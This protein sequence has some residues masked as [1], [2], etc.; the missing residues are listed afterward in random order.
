MRMRTAVYRLVKLV[1]RILWIKVVYSVCVRV[2]FV[3]LKCAKS[4]LAFN[5]QYTTSASAT[6]APRVPVAL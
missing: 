2:N 1:R 6:E 3:M 4:S 5:G